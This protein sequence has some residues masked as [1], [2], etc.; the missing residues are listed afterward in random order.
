MPSLVSRSGERHQIVRTLTT[1]GPAKDNDIIVQT[2]STQATHAVIKLDSGRF[3]IST[4]ERKALMVVNDKKSRKHVLEHGDEVTLGDATLVF[5]LWD[6]ATISAPVQDTHHER[7]DAYERL[8]AFSARLADAEDIDTLLNTL[9]DE[10]IVLTGASKG[11]L[12]LQDDDAFRIK[13]A[14]NVNNE[15]IPDGAN[16][17]SDSIVAKVIESGEP[18]IVSDALN[19]TIFSSS[20]SVIQL[21]LC[22]VMC[23]PLRF[24]QN[25][26]GVIY[27]GNDNV[28]NL[29]EQSLLET[30]RV[31]CGQAALLVAHAI[32]RDA[33]SEDNARLR[34]K[35]EGHRYGE[36]LGTCTPMREVFARIEKVSQANVSVL[37][38]G[39]TGTGKEM[40]AREIHRRSPR[41]NGPFVAVNCG[42]FAE[43][44]IE[45]ALFGHKRGAFTGA[46]T[47]KQGCFQAAHGGTLFLDE[48]GEMPRQLQVKLLRA[49]QERKVSRLG[50]NR[51][52]PVDIRL[53]TATHVDLEEAVSNGA[54]RQDL[55]YRINVLSINLPA[56]KDRGTD[57]LLLAQHFLEHYGKEYERPKVHFA[58]EAKRCLE[59]HGWPGNIRELQ[60]RIRKAVLLADQDVIEGVDLELTEE[61]MVQKILPLADAKEQ[62]QASYI[63]RALELNGGNRTKTARDL[64]VDPRTIFRY[65]EKQRT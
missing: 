12:L 15:T 5:D 33:L 8:M 62:F 51:A 64:K 41:R 9:M 3:V 40:V 28:V 61:S 57:I 11:F 53:L 19:D 21:R 31:F 32:Q 38:R 49:I 18:I 56:L 59:G 22:S 14:R 1:I 39:E 4:S 43:N 44:L 27:V 30:L 23:V 7:I 2:H 45:S 46:H 55:Y 6:S 16:A 47:D 48:I 20:R 24:A 10:V 36:L 29:F 26:L 25:T 37:I 60:N 54:F 63:E 17:V 58:R 35:L 13:S 50:A 42:A 65:L 52:E 34:V